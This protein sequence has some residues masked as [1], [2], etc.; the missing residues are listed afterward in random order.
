[1]PR[2]HDFRI[3]S[4]FL[5]FLQI[6]FVAHT[7]LH[8]FF[9]QEIEPKR[10]EAAVTHKYTAYIAKDVVEDP[11]NH[12][13]LSNVSIVYHV[14]WGSEFGRANNQLVAILHA[15]D[16]A[17]DQHGEIAEDGS[18]ASAIV[19]VSGWAKEL[20]GSWLSPNPIN[21]YL[22]MNWSQA[23]ERNLPIVD[24]NRLSNF[25]NIS[26]LKKLEAAKAYYYSRD[27]LDSI[28][29]SKLARRRKLILRKLI[30]LVPDNR[31]DKLNHLKNY[32]KKRGLGGRYVTIHK[33][34]LE[35]QC[36]DRVGP[37]LVPYECD[38]DPSYIKDLLRPYYGLNL[39][40]VPIV[41]ISDM[42]QIEPLEKLLSDPE[43]GS[44]VIISSSAFPRSSPA[45]DV[46]QD[47]M[48]AIHSD[49]LIGP[50][51]SSMTLMIGMMRVAMGAH[52]RTN[53]VYVREKK[54][55]R[56]L[57]FEKSSFE[58]CGDCIFF[59]DGRNNTICGKSTVYP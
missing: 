9:I 44:N 33:R 45:T 41:V 23:L 52:P 30:S 47:M 17:F 36:R 3:S 18:N 53:L 6:V 32:L 22:D 15:L 7:A 12:L 59:C 19:V 38:M 43:I 20:M 16:M 51:V 28:T 24:Y 35:G 29:P 54:E 13:N 10:S 2:C 49:F 14:G 37:N 42:Q 27:N 8:T 25:S 11:L 34:H 40:R 5:L 46:I 50:R 55:K 4:R 21:P 56:F 26:D 48:V 57:V 39:S 58:V 31:L 1:M